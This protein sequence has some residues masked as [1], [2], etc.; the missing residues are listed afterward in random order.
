MGRTKELFE[1]FQNEIQKDFEYEEYLYN[2]Y[3]ETVT[4]GSIYKE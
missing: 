2:N 4:I 1:E 3:V